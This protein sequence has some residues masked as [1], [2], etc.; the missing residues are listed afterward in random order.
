LINLYGQL[1]TAI[2]LIADGNGEL[3]KA[4]ELELDLKKAVLGVRCKRCVSQ[5]THGYVGQLNR[6]K[7]K[8][9]PN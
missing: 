1:G 8:R 5:R 6:H 9:P 3:T 7:K 4:L 2:S